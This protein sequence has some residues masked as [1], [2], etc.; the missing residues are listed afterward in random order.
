MFESGV[1]LGLRGESEEVDKIRILFLFFV[2]L[3]ARMFDQLKFVI[4]FLCN[5]KAHQST[6]HALKLTV[7]I[8]TLYFASH[9]K[10][11]N[12]THLKSIGQKS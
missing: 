11:L 5:K 6:S 4:F 8:I 12:K 9:L 10:S 7:N 2:L 3:V 1:V